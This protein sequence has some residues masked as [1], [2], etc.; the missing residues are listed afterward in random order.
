MCDLDMCA[1]G[2]TWQASF[3]PTSRSELLASLRSMPSSLS[4][5]LPLPLTPSPSLSLSVPV[6]TGTRVSL[7]LGIASCWLRALLKSLQ[8]QP[9]SK[10]TH[11]DRRVPL[12]APSIS[13]PPSASKS[14]LSL[15]SP[16]LSAL[17]FLL[18]LARCDIVGG[19]CAGV[20]ACSIGVAA[21]GNFPRAAA[22]C[23]VVNAC[24]AA[25]TSRR[26]RAASSQ[27]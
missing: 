15:V 16:S 5:P 18:P 3:Q 23:D 12:S 2:R 17:C 19:V 4:L 1:G 27:L 22:I 21:S 24:T 9:S 20:L 6:A 26:S 7:C 11:G 8:A 25:G 13:L 10:K 14:S